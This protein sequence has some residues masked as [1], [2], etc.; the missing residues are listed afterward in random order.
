MFEFIDDFD[1]CECED[2]IV[3][4]LP[5]GDK[6]CI[7]CNNAARDPEDDEFNDKAWDDEDADEDDDDWYG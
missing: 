6:I 7:K 5:D 3:R 4:V 2:P 1:V